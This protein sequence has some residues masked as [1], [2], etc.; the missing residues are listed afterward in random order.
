[1]AYIL[2]EVDDEDAD[3][4]NEIQAV[5]LKTASKFFTLHRAIGERVGIDVWDKSVKVDHIDGNP[6]NN[7]RSNLRAATGAQNRQ[8]SAKMSHNKSGYK[9]VGQYKGSRKFRATITAFNKREY[10]GSY[11]T[12]EEAARAWD[13]RAI[14]LHGEFARTN[15]PKEN[16]A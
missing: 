1:M 14:E 15:F 3:L 13:K 7:H 5:H 8:N 9:G 16:Y 10:I 12:A 6:L 2:I 4:L 11:D